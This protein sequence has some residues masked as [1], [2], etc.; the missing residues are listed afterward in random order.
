MWIIC[1]EKQSWANEMPPNM[2]DWELYMELECRMTSSRHLPC[3]KSSRLGKKKKKT[4]HRWNFVMKASKSWK[5]KA[6]LG[7]TVCVSERTQHRDRLDNSVSASHLVVPGSIMRQRIS[8]WK[9]S[10]K[11]SG[12]TLCHL[13]SGCSGS[14]LGKFWM[15]LGMK[16]QEEERKSNS[17]MTKIQK[18]EVI[19][20]KQN[21]LRDNEFVLAAWYRKGDKKVR[22]SWCHRKVIYIGKNSSWDCSEPETTCSTWTSR[23]P[24]Q[25]SQSIGETYRS[26][27]LQ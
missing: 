12:L 1:W 21:Q 17:R 22:W 15:P 11:V 8:R 4:T 9:G 7:A 24:E 23:V 19:K 13:G 5:Y 10:L 16:I 20:I 14:Y 3:N 27:V 6:K 18:I 25:M 26:M 2:K